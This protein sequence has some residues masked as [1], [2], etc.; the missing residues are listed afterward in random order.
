MKTFR[1]EEII[2]SVSMKVSE[3][4]YIVAL[5]FLTF[6][7]CSRDFFR[8]HEDAR[9]ELVLDSGPATR[10]HYVDNGGSASFVWDAGSSMI[11]VLSKGGAISSWEDGNYYSAMHISLVDPEQKN[12]V[13]RATSDATLSQDA[14]SV[15]DAL[16]FLSP[17]EGNDLCQ[18]AADASC[19]SVTFSMPD[20][21]FQSASSRLEEFEDYC[22]IRAESSI[23]SIPSDQ[24]KNFA[25]NSTTFRA[26]PA[27]FRF[28]L[29][30]NTSEDIFIESVK[31]SSDKLFPD[32][33]CWMTDGATAK[34][35]EP[36][37]KSGYFSTIKT[38]IP[39]GKGQLIPAKNG[40][41]ISKGTYYSMCLPF[42][43]ESSMSGATLAFIL[44]TRDKI[45]TFNVP[46][47]DFFRN[48]IHKMFESNKIYTFNFTMNDNS[49]E[50]ENVA[51]S[52]WIDDPFYL[53][54]EEISAFFQVSASFWVQVRANFYTFEFMRM[55][56]DGSSGTMWGECNIGEYLY[57]ASD[58]TFN[59]N[60]VTPSG[61]SD[62]D[63]LAPYFEG[64]TDFKWKTPSRA[65]YEE[66]FS[67]PESNIE[68]CMD[69]ESGVPGIRIQSEYNPGVFVF[70]PCS[71]HI[72]EHTEYPADGSTVIHRTF[73]G[74]YWTRDEADGQNAYML[75]FAFKQVET[76][77]DDV[78]TFSPFSKV[79]DSGNGLYEF[80]PS[81]K[82]ETYT[83][84]PIIRND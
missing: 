22:Y 59:W 75:H 69:E 42:D 29:S 44:E 57:F 64:V 47:A 2:I 43:D 21:F 71:G 5:A 45:Y 49:V 7:G 1:R 28:N 79:L 6:V 41:T 18:L 15:S 30:N 16:F 56:G 8:P 26:I 83:V 36:A 84:R 39:S 19:V 46:A 35:G 20:S 68:M 3:K 72:T 48:S 54:T 32:R 81:S 80:V 33:L 12:R 34:V 62:V 50:L 67:I 37:D 73:N 82:T 27:T 76:S 77:K 38:S 63:Y 52:D 74:N 60:S 66:L 23:M 61:E 65:D 11:A 10:A 17:V 53:P 4:I 13:L 25:A 40:E 78:S 9:I 58:V 24:D 70:L 31:I 51:I 55:F 14:A